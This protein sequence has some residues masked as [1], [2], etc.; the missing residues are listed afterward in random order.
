MFTGNCS[1]AR[2]FAPCTSISVC[3]PQ[4][5][6]VPVDILKASTL[7]EEAA[8]GDAN[9]VPHR[10]PAQRCQG[11]LQALGASRARRVRLRV[12]KRVLSDRAPSQSVDTLRL[13]RELEKLRTENR[14][15]RMNASGERAHASMCY[16]RVPNSMLRRAAPADVAKSTCRNSAEQIY[17]ERFALT[18]CNIAK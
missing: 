1:H 17:Q 9:G 16:A 18:G 8:Q 14:R 10:P 4:A 12:H 6:E 5:S 2:L 7:H 11:L 3:R 15:L 13:K